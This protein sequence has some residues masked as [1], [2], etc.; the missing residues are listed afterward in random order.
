[1]GPTSGVTFYHLWNHNKD[2]FHELNIQGSLLNGE[3]TEYF[4]N[5]KL[6]QSNSLATLCVQ[7]IPISFHSCKNIG[8]YLINSFVTRDLNL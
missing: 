5:T 4:V 6:F 2:K 7:N 1:M 8:H 3:L